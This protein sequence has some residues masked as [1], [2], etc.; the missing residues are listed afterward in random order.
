[1]EMWGTA[2]SKG[3]KLTMMEAIFACLIPISTSLSDSTSI[4]I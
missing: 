1:M 3:M 2:L 4:L